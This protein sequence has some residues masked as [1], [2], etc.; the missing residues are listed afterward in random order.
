MSSRAQGASF[1]AKK[2]L[3]DRSLS[4]SDARAR[5]KRLESALEHSAEVL[6]AQGPIGIFV[7][8]NTLHAY[9]RLP[10]ELGVEEAAR[11]YGAEPYWSLE[12]FRAELLR[13][14]IT[15]DDVTRELGSDEIVA[16]GL[17]RHAIALHLLLDVDEEPRASAF[18]WSLAEGR[19]LADLWAAAQ[20]AWQAPTPVPTASL[21]RGGATGPWVHPLLIRLCAAFLD[22]GVAYWRMPSLNEGFLTA[23][24]RLLRQPWGPPEPWMRALRKSFAEIEGTDAA[25]V[26]LHCL[27]DL[28]VR[29]ADWVDYLSDRLLALPGWGGMF[30]QLELRPDRAPVKAPPARLIDF[31]A[32]RLLIERE[33]E[34]AGFGEPAEASPSELASGPYQLYG[35]AK[36]ARWSAAKLQSLSAREREQLAGLI[37]Q[38]DETA[39][40]RLFHRAYERHYREEI[41]DALAAHEPTPT[42]K[43][44][45]QVVCCIDEREES[46]RRHLEEIAPDVETFGA[47][48]YF[49]VAMAYQGIDDAH[50]RPLCPI[51]ITPDHHVQELPLPGLSTRLERRMKQRRA[52]GSLARGASVGSRTFVRGTLWSSALGL[53]SAAPLVARVLFPRATAS[54]RKNVSTVSLAKVDTRLD[55]SAFSLEEQATIV[56]DQ[57]RDMGLTE[58]APLVIVLG[59]GSHSL[60]NPHESAHDCGACGGGRGGPNA[61]AFA[62][63]ANDPSVRAR[64]AVHVPE[65]TWFV[66]GVHDTAD[67]AIELFD[68]DCVPASLGD[69][70]ARARR[71]LDEARGR[72]ALERSR[73]FETSASSPEAALRHVEGRAEDLAQPRPEYGHA[74]NATCFIGRRATVRGLFLD[75]R[76]FLMSY[77]PGQDA[78]GAILERVLAAVVPVGAGINLEYY[79]SFVDQQKY[80]AGT[81]LPHN[82]SGLVGVMDGHASDLRTGLPWQMVDIHETMRLLEIVEAE[83]ETVQKAAQATPAVWRLVKNEWLTIATLDPKSRELH[84][85]DGGHFVPYSSDR[86]ELPVFASSEERFRG[87]RDHL[88]PARIEAR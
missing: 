27:D 12:A 6:P 83:R 75:R 34:R 10:F 77:D 74:S 8:H 65:S 19:E 36:A 33:V 7:H 44:H 3:P 25:E 20:D 40:R 70:L 58:L 46:L 71:D 85:L 1:R 66:G 17:T 68:L 32:V 73:R 22:Q 50:A 14:R 64:L 4:H 49:G 26:V 88:A 53:L 47:P 80:G 52:L 69:R 87:R 72:D 37:S 16:G 42:P 39:R 86:R 11:R 79:F 57:L 43:P 61:R 48:G 30:R 29:E 41:L 78:S 63:M 21:A 45:Y 51:S 31:V 76:A 38:L 84:L 81:K 55:L 24:A 54:L 2:A 82:V 13:G 9:E 18:E 59:H 5:Q 60:N 62:Q 35:L 67:D 23:T 56:E 28:G 15:R